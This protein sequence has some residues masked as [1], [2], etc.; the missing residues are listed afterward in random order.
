MSVLASGLSQ[1]LRQLRRSPGLFALVVIT[2]T[3]GI[4]ATTAMFGVV[5]M[6]LL[7]PLPYPNASRLAEV[8]L[9]NSKTGRPIQSLTA[10]A[11]RALR[12]QTAS[13]IADV[14]T[15]QMGAGVISVGGDATLD[16]TPRVSPGLLSLLGVSPRLG[17]LFFDADT[18]SPDAAHVVLISEKL[19]QTRFGG[20]PSALGQRITIDDE[21]YA[22]IGVLPEGFRFP[23]RCDVWRPVV[24]SA[25]SP[26]PG[27]GPG[28]GAG[29]GRYRTIVSLRPGVAR[30]ALNRHL[31]DLSPRLQQ[32]GA[33]PRDQVFDLDDLLQARFAR[34]YSTAFY[35]MLAA[36]VAMLLVAMVNVTNLLLVRA[37]A[38]SQEFALLGALGATRW[39]LLRQ[40]ALESGVLALLAAAGG[41]LV[42]NACLAIVVQLM[43]P[44]MTYLSTITRT[45]WDPRV[46]AFTTLIAT[47]TCFVVGALPTLRVS[48]LDLIGALQ[49]RSAAVVGSTDERWQS[50]LIAAQLAIVL[51]LLAGAGVLLRSFVHLVSVEPGLDR[52]NLLVFDLQIPDKRYQA[53]GAAITLLEQLK[54]MVEASPDVEHATVSESAPPLPGRATHGVPEA[55]GQPPSGPAVDLLR[56]QIEPNYF[57]TLRIPVRE[58]R[59]FGAD[60]P[61]TLAVISSSLARRLWNGASPIGHQVRLD[62]KEPWL[63]VI[64]VANDVALMSPEAPDLEPMD[65]YVP[66]QRSA[67][68]WVFSLIVRTRGTASNAAVLQHVKDQLHRLDDRLPLLETRTMDQR[69]AEWVAKPRLFVGL[70]SVFAAIAVL[71]AGVGVYGTAAYWVARRRREI[72]IRIAL[73][74]RPASVVAMVLRRGLRLALIGGAIGMAAAFAGR[75]LLESLL[76]VTDARN[77]IT[78]VA[79]ATL[80]VS[81]VAIACYLPARRA[82]RIDPSMVLRGE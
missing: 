53:P 57:T 24:S 43:P 33:L 21:S 65:T 31:R 5:D 20:A 50:L 45:T 3:L 19:W 70:A 25:K 62:P 6:M 61:E 64:G 11:V 82:S 38:R 46:L 16:S 14:E 76:F 59:A 54:T 77:P 56:R 9:R 47:A 74:A 40:M 27:G 30:E 8:N 49:N 68:P 63:T 44:E 28:P 18:A 60:D 1:L 2:L 80:L 39:D 34:R 41:L 7:R 81:L 66:H 15:Y 58:G 23:E 12:D 4:G 73:G 67:H 13:W 36:A 69:Y 42:A 17:R 78:V 52:Q 72:G 26:G 71:L 55:D 48:R 51:V 10:D 22:I 29:Q 35:I 32:A 79:V 37:S 75:Q